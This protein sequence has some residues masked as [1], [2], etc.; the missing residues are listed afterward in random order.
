MGY[1]L[2]GRFK[3]G[4]AAH[5]RPR[6]ARFVMESLE[7]RIAPA[8]FNVNS[9][10]DVLNPPAGTV[11]L[12]SA[13]QAANHTPGPNTINLTLP[14]VYRITTLGTTT[15]NTAGEL[16]ITSTSN[17]NIINTS[18]GTAVVNGGGLNRVF[19]V[20]PTAST[21]PFSVTFQ[22]FWIVGGAASPGDGADGSG[23][24]IR[25]QGGASIVLT[26]M[27]VAGNTATADGGGISM[28]SVNNDSTGTLT[29][30]NS[31]I[32]YNYA[33][34]A[35]GGIETDGTGLVT[36]NSGSVIDH[37][38]CVNQGAGIWLDAG[39]AA[40][41]VTGAIVSNNAAVTMLG[42]GIGNAGA[43][44]V[45]I[46]SSLIEDNF[47]GGNGGGFA[48][49]ANTGNLTVTNSLF[50]NNRSAVN[51]GGIQEGGPHTT[52]SYSFFQGNSA[53]NGYGGGVFVNG[54]D[55]SISGSQF[56][57]NVAVNGAGI[58][59]QA[60]TLSLTAGTLFGN[61]T[62]ATNEGTGGNGAG[63]DAQTGVTSV[64]IANALFLDNTAHNGTLANG[65]GI[66]QTT[67]TLTISQSQFSRNAADLGG[68]ISFTGTKLFVY[69]TTFDHNRSLNGGGAIYFAG[70][71]SFGS[72]NA[73]VVFDDTIAFNATGGDGGGILDVSTGGLFLL[74]DTVNNN[75]ATGNGGGIAFEGTGQL[76]IKN[77]IIALN[78]AGLTGNDVF[79]GT[80][81]TVMDQGGNL[82]G[83][84]A[85]ASGFSPGTRTGN[86][87]LGPLLNNG[88]FTAGAPAHGH[89]VETEALLPG[90]Q[91]IGT[92][93]AGGPAADE[94]G[95]PASNPESI[96]AYQP[97]YTSTWTSDQIFAENV[98]EV[99]FNRPAP[100]GAVTAIVNAVHSGVS[101]TSMI[102]ALENSPA[103]RTQ[104]V[105]N[106]IQTYLHR[107]PTS[108]EI[109][110]STN[111]LA[112]GNNVRQLDAIII[113]LDEYY[114]LHGGTNAAFVEALS[115]DV[116]H[117]AATPDGPTA[118]YA[119]QLAGG[120]TTRAVATQ[121]LSS[122]GYLTD[123]VLAG[124]ESYLGVVL[125]PA[126][127]AGVVSYLQAGG[128]D[129]LLDAILL[130]SSYASRT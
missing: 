5:A 46:A 114:Q 57:Q 52:I 102:N 18:G 118:S 103:Y 58:E 9:F 128:S 17:L 107:P 76:A 42:G 25:A 111:F 91:A 71:G 40:L 121:L 109:T 22:G 13:I 10:A 106:A 123:K 38:V 124:Y 12:R 96:G 80:G 55:V 110:N 50:L 15:D 53:P 90:S 51:G 44:N 63:L 45:N 35:G 129:S 73:S 98:M 16:A 113:G 87:L 130:S 21:T 70:T 4:A 75:K 99:L 126:D 127:V 115:E 8:V 86:P 31:T 56:T 19:D 11:T 81:L 78:T 54:Q 49:A 26:N 32:R 94:R 93:V 62:L 59:D 72:G 88:G 104:L 27:T 112:A 95:F 2:R 125:G 41:N 122:P 39:G 30:N 1:Q 117:Q 37:N 84:T 101:W 33:G 69:Q 74:N 66:N 67:G 7:D 24:G 3:N 34:D 48:D 43:G 36:V 60:T 116:L 105:V 119:Q 68:A 82:I 23:G 77:T 85:G 64:T 6:G 65:G 92:G 79:T 61:H 100:A 108:G 89:V 14:G 20:N 97:Q 29:V 28:E 83:T 120:A 47:A